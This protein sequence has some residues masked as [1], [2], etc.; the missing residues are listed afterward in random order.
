MDAPTDRMDHLE[1]LHRWTD[2]SPLTDVFNEMY[3]EVYSDEIDR[4]SISSIPEEIRRVILTAKEVWAHPM[5]GSISV[6]SAW[7]DHGYPYERAMGTICPTNEQDFV[8]LAL[9]G[10]PEKSKLHEYGTNV[11]ETLGHPHF[12]H[13]NTPNIEEVSFLAF[14]ANQVRL[15]QRP[16]EQLERYTDRVFVP[17]PWLMTGD[18][19]F[20]LWFGSNELLADLYAGSVSK[21]RGMIECIRSD[22]AEDRCARSSVLQ[23]GQ[24][25][26]ALRMGK[27][28]NNDQFV[29][30]NEIIP[31]Y[32]HYFSGE[33][34]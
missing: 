12:N 11:I 33:K 29:M 7:S 24:F 2:E 27:S 15:V 6:D 28:P 32:A 17:Y 14:P 13:R 4:I 10:V 1:F 9:H 21:V 8:V 25:Y 18:D 31:S 30:I 19:C 20:D 34:E 26:P 3:N 16:E 22:W 23:K 5:A